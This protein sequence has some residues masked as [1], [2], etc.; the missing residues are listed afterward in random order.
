MPLKVQHPLPIIGLELYQLGVHTRVKKTNKT[1]KHFFFIFDGRG[2][3]MFFE[4]A[5]S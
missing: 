1:K 4:P 3:P 2:E 5:H